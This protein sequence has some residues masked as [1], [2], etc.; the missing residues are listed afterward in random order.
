MIEIGS[1]K[2]AECNYE[3]SSACIGYAKRLKRQIQFFDT[4]NNKIGIINAYG[5]LCACTHQSDGKCWYS[6]ADFCAGQKELSFTQ[7]A[8]LVKS[9]A[10][11]RTSAGFM[12]YKHT[13]N[14]QGATQ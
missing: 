10:T 2:F 3:F 14:H 7:S 8:N 4:D 11:H 1:S 12:E 6:Y 5:V 13:F 9:L